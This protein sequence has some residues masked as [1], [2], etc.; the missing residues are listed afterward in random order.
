MEP[1][2]FRLGG[3]TGPTGAPNTS[4][5]GGSGGRRMGLEALFA[6]GATEPIAFLACLHRFGCLW[7]MSSQARQK[8]WLE[9]SRQ[10]TM[11]SEVPHRSHVL[12]TAD[13]VMGSE[14]TGRPEATVLGRAT[15]GGGGGAGGGP[16][17]S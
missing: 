10:R 17:S 2:A 13:I 14:L 9:H 11:A 3:A 5:F 8:V 1:A 4:P 16:I 15:G 12:A 7:Y 6:A